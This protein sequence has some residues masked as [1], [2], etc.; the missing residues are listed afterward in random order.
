MDDDEVAHR[1]LY[2]VLAWLPNEHNISFGRLFSAAA[3]A[4]A[5]TSQWGSDGIPIT[6]VKRICN[7]YFN[8]MIETHSHR[9]AKLF[10][11]INAML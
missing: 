6:V 8:E 1:I 9:A 2:S 4:T 5:E 7:L 3:E 11:I 10:N